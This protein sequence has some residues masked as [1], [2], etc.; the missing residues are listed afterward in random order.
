M[1]GGGAGIS[2]NSEACSVTNQIKAS[3]RGAIRDMLSARQIA[4]DHLAEDP[5]TLSLLVMASMRGLS[6]L[7]CD[8]SSAEDL[9]RVADLAAAS[10]VRQHDTIS[11]SAD[12]PL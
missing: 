11:P 12:R 7:A 3:L 1:Q 2:E 10:C 9:Y 4:G 8:G 6:Q 5:H